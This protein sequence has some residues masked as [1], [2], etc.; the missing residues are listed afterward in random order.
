MMP[1]IYFKTMDEIPEGLREHVK[2][3]DGKLSI[4][5]VPKKELDSFRDNNIGLLR[6]RDE[7]K[8]VVSK[9]AS[10]ASD[11]DALAT[12]LTK[13][14]DVEKQVKDGKLTAKEDIDREVESRTKAQ[15][16]AA[17][18]GIRERDALLARERAEKGN[19]RT[20]LDQTKIRGV[21][22]QAVI[23]P[24]SGANPTAL[25]DILER[26]MRHFKVNEKGQVVRMDGE[27]VVYGADGV[28]PMSA[29]EWV[30]ELLTNAP[31][32]AKISSGGGAGGG[33]GGREIYGG[34]PEAEF[35]KL[36]PERRI[37][38]AREAAR[39]ARR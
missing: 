32:F 9:Y 23:D 22:T 19:L 11:P 16:E 39:R 8:G 6:E 14:R 34:L 24:T 31:H 35:M 21:I 5:V 20:E 2:T 26:A 15:R 3:V 12:E 13:L 30:A 36:S 33:A 7:L 25:E 27:T 38:M 29:K 1:D 17:E 37:T 28:K 18:Q 4:N 10:I